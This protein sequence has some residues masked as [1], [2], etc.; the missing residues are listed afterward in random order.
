MV[1][2]LRSLVRTYN[3]ICM[4]VNIFGITFGQNRVSRGIQNLLSNF[5]LIFILNRLIAGGENSLIWST[6]TSLNIKQSDNI[7]QTFS[8]YTLQW[9]YIYIKI[10]NEHIFGI[11]LLNAFAW[12][13]MKNN[14][15]IHGIISFPSV[16][17]VII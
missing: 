1:H 14:Q 9:M 11:C 6:K 16:C 10:R 12:Y 15:K 7:N 3:L 17:V 8:N 13:F 2:P 4:Q 5:K